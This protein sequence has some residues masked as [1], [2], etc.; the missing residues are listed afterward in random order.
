MTKPA[1][2][3]AKDGKLAEIPIP[4]IRVVASYE[5]DYRPNY[6]RSRTYLRS[7]TF[8][9][10]AGDVV[11][12]DLDNEDEDWLE[13]YNDGQNRLPAEKLEV[14]IWKLETVCGEANEERMAIHAANATEKGLVISYQEKCA[15]M[16]GTEAL[17]KE[18]AVE[19]LQDL[20][21]RPA[22]LEAVY[23][24]WC[25]KR[26][27]TGKPCLRRLQPPPAPNDANPFN[28]FRQREK[29]NRPQ[30]RRRRENDAVSFDK[31]RLIRRGM[32]MAY[33]IVE[34]Q[35]KREEKKAEK[36]RCE[37][38]AQLLQMKLKHEPRAEIEAI[39]SEFAKRRARSR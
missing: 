11:E 9:A 23:E 31:L 29:T 8:G 27:R 18:K 25:D 26:R 24:Y 3:K 37:R 35:L 12:Y 1:D 6:Q 13:K 28:V 14:M 22:I 34:L 33:A 10:P 16:A 19:L 7:R 5:S 32:E 30:T 17:P 4:E 39:E 2:G 20:S 21:G 15:M 38:D 36:M